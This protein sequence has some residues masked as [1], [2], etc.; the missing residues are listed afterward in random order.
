MLS[1]VPQTLS[2]LSSFGV[3][4]CSRPSKSHAALVP[5]SLDYLATFGPQTLSPFSALGISRC[6]LPSDSPSALGH[7]PSESLTALCSQ[8]F[9]PLST[10]K[11]SHRPW[12]SNSLAAL[13]PLPSDSFAALGPVSVHTPPETRIRDALRRRLPQHGNSVLAKISQTREGRQC[14]HPL[15]LLNQGVLICCLHHDGAYRLSF[16]ASAFE[17]L[18]ETAKSSEGDRS[19]AEPSYPERAL[20]R[21]RPRAEAGPR[22]SRLTTASYQRL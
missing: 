21:A 16:V 12:P 7:L 20:L 13:V 4:R 5:L 8:I 9:S 11:L 17:C 22:T 14:T 19:T 18:C 2:P 3:S 6:S 10:F 15:V 1:L